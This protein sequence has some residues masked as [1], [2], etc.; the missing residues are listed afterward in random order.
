MRWRIA[1]ENRNRGKFSSRD[2]LRWARNVVQFIFLLTMPELFAQAFSGAKVIVA[3]LGNGGMLS[4]STFT[5]RLAVLCLLTVLAGRIF[6]GWAC[7]FGAVGDWLYQLASFVQKRA[8]KKLPRIPEKLLHILQKTKYIVLAAVLFLCFSGRTDIVTKYSPWTVF[9]LLTAGNFHL[10]S[11]G[12]AVILLFLIIAGMVLQ[13]RFFCQCLC[14]MGAIFSL[15]PELPLTSWKRNSD[16]CI[17]GCQ[18]CRK[19]C[20][21]KIKLDENPFWEGEC[22]RC[23]RCSAVCPKKNIKFYALRH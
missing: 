22:I 8:G 6:C 12:I 15:L 18:A 5:V 17:P 21:V 23:G 4:W 16:N 10:G 7:A 2:K 14:P 19:N 1:M 20:P 9:S 11:Y 13:E 3:Q